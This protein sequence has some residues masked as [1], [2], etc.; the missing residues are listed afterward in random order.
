M[1]NNTKV[2]LYTRVSTEDQR[3]NFSLAAQLELL[4]K[5]AA[6]N[7]YQIFREYVE[8]GFTGTTGDRPAFQDL[9]RDAKLQRFELILVYKID[10]FY[11]NTRHL[12]NLNEEL[13][14]VGVKIRSATEPIDTSTFFGKF[15]LSLMGSIGQLERDTFLD[16]S[17]LGRLRRAREGFYSG[18]KPAKFGFQYNGETRKLEINEKEAEAVRHI[19]S[20]YIKPDSSIL[21]VAKELRQLN[22]KT[23]EG[24][25]FGTDTVHGILRDS[26]Y[27]GTWYANRYSKGGKLKPREEWIEVKVPAITS[28]QYFSKAQQLLDVRRNYSVR[29]D[30]YK[31]LL[32]GLIKCGCCGNTV[33]GTA[34]KQMTVKNGKT[35]GPY[36]KIYYRCTHFVKNLFENKIECNLRYMQA[37]DLE[38]VVWKEI[39]KLLVNPSL[40]EKALKFEERNS[41]VNKNDVL[42]ESKKL[43]KRKNT[44]LNEEQRI[45]EAYRQNIIT[46]EQLKG[47]LNELEVNKQNCSQR[48]LEINLLEK[49]TDKDSII[50]YAT[51]YVAKMASGI[52]ECSFEAK[53]NILLLFNTKI[54]P[55]IDGSIDILCTIPKDSES[56]GNSANF[57]SCVALPKL[58]QFLFLQTCPE[59][60]SESFSGFQ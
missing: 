46:L 14:N 5:Y 33:A 38:E 22:Y 36:L 20:S 30:K 1:I 31:Y 21:K 6:D 32:Q 53:R 8:E 57:F 59:S 13:E 47:Q 50:K 60:Q 28:V 52:K 49:S 26:I 42:S 4:R 54:V 27:I 58:G 24:K 19:F 39:E 51:D 17:K 40:I 35:Y 29:N 16:R 48:E 56:A 37:D 7:K 23:K 41:T 3:N 9:V 11:R 18:S 2:A 25:Q 10:R 34:D 55:M 45:L 15:V 12:L 44:L 43:E